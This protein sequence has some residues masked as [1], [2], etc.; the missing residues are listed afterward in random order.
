VAV[1]RDFMNNR[2]SLTARIT[3]IFNTLKNSYYAW[4][5]NFTADNWRKPET[6]I[7]YLSLIYNFGKN[8]SVKNTRSNS[9]NES[10]H[11]KEIN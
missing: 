8:G 7:F 3:D 9:G 4:G 10:V 11:S 5:T 6:R 1:K 2:L